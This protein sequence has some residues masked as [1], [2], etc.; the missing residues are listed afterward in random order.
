MT[1]GGNEKERSYTLV[2]VV[3]AIIIIVAIVGYA[4]IIPRP[5]PSTNFHQLGLL[6]ETSENYNFSSSPPPPS[7]DI[8]GNATVAVY[9]GTYTTI[10]PR[11]NITLRIELQNLGTGALNRPIGDSWPVENGLVRGPSGN[12]SPQDGTYYSG[13][14]GYYYPYG[15]AVFMGNV[16]QATIGSATPLAVYYPGVFSCPAIGGFDN[17]TIQANSDVAILTGPNTPLN[18]TL[19]SSFS[20]SGYYTSG[21]NFTA[22]YTNKDYQ[23]SYFPQGVYTIV[24]ED[25]WGAV[26]YMYFTIT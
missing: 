17:Y 5:M 3:L 20:F 13:C 25:E 2:A 16:S 24:V 10:S 21:S 26:V 11:E 23:F 22:N 9:G 19:F 6:L 14:F 12:L 15:F 18:L 4:A 8:K 1:E 7:A